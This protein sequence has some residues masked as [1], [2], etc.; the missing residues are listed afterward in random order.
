MAY[1]TIEQHYVLA[2]AHTVGLAAQ[3]LV[4]KFLPAVTS[5]SGLSGEKQSIKDLY[6][7]FE[8]EDN[9]ERFKP[10]A[11]KDIGKSRRWFIPHAPDGYVG[12]DSW[13]SMRINYNPQTP[14]IQA[15]LGAIQRSIDNRIVTDYFG[16]NYVGQ[17]GTTAQAFDSSMIVGKDDASTIID[18]ME[19]AKGLFSK[20]GVDIDYEEI[21]MAIPSL[22]ER[23][24]KGLGIYT[25][26]DYQNEKVMTSTKLI[27]VGGVNL[28][29]YEGL[30]TTTESGATVI[31]CPI[32]C[33]SG[34]AFG[35]W[36][37]VKTR[38]DELQEKSYANIV[39]VGHMIAASRI[40]E[41]KCAVI[42]LEVA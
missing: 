33:K 2:F 31:Q 27:P 16:T 30:P 8:L 25:S 20:N 41:A 29:R 15:A 24:L 3:Q 28:I 40:E 39:Y 7:S 23:E 19:I 13:D 38:V 12:I 6:G 36:A 1:E 42:N 5:Q 4:S 34:M 18:K 22:G 32:W 14:L 35:R 17:D 10:M 26:S 9:T 21:Y 37:G 11:I